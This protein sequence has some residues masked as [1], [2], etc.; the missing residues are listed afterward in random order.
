M[1][2]IFYFSLAF[3]SL[4]LAFEFAHFQDETVDSLA[5]TQ[6]SIPK[7]YDGRL[8]CAVQCFKAKSPK[9]DGFQEDKNVNNCLLFGGP[10]AI[11]TSHGTALYLKPCKSAFCTILEYVCTNFDLCL[12]MH[13]NEAFCVKDTS[14]ATSVLEL[15]FVT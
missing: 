9:C 5:T 11:K 10:K 1:L 12:A 8:F 3:F 13:S 14:A 7:K 2:V 15:Q 4:S 6:I